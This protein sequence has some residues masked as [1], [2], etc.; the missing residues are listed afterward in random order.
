MTDS[1]QRFSAF[2]SAISLLVSFMVVIF[3]MVVER[4]IDRRTDKAKEKFA[5]GLMSVSHTMISA[6]FLGVFVFPLTA[7]LQ[8]LTHG[9]DPLAELW[10]WL[11]AAT[12]TTVGQAMGFGV[13]FLWPLLIAALGRWRALSLYDEIARKSWP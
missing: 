13:S 7:Y 5:D 8:A 10:R 2:W 4:R 9:I 6:V 12:L 1:W 11:S 3:L